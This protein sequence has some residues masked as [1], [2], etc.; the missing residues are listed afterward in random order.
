M[1]TYPHWINEE[2]INQ[3]EID[4]SGYH[5]RSSVVYSNENMVLCSVRNFEIIAYYYTSTDLKK[6]SLAGTIV[7]ES[8]RL[9]DKFIVADS[10]SPSIMFSLFNVTCENPVKGSYLSETFTESKW[11]T[12]LLICDANQNNIALL[13]F[14][15]E[16]TPVFTDCYQCCSYLY[17]KHFHSDVTF[18][19]R[20]SYEINRS[21]KGLDKNNIMWMPKRRVKIT[22]PEKFLSNICD[23]F[24]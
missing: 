15:S 3:K 14:L 16:A 9:C 18:D 24:S 22:F 17:K 2:V 20:M 6:N 11:S 13:K 5:I 1:T 23:S 7:S 12:M 8:L 19:N 4:L 21:N 10:S